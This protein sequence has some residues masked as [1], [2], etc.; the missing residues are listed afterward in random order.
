MGRWIW[1]LV[2]LVVVM[3][4]TLSNQSVVTVSFWQWPI[5]SG[6]L[7]LVLVGAGILGALVTYFGSLSHHVR[8]SRRI[9]GLEE[10]LR[11]SE[12]QQAPVAPP[13]RSLPSEEIR[14]T[15]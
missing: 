5:Y 11:A 1:L 6:P 8:Q 13:P 9:R 14:R 4:F 7:A 12:S 2:L 15:P 10:R 3:L